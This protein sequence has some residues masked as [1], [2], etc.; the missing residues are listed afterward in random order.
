M[1]DFLKNVQAAAEATGKDHSVTKA[2]ADF[3]R[4]VYP[5]GPVRLRF[6]SYVELGKHEKTW[7]GQTK[8]KELVR[9]GFEVSG[10][11]HKPVIG[12]DGVARPLVLYVEETLSQDPKANWV[13]L[14]SLLN[15]DR[16]ATHAVQLLGRAYK[17]MLTHRKYKRRDDPA[18]QDKWTGLDYKIRGDGGY[19]IQAPFYEDQETGD[20]KPLQ[21][22]PPI[23]KMAA[24]LW[25]NPSQEQWDSIFIEGEYP[26]RKN[27]AGVVTAPAKS[28][29]AIQ[30]RVLAAVNFKGSPLHTML[31]KA[32]ANLDLGQAEQADYDDGPQGE[33]PAPKAGTKPAASAQ[34]DADFDADF[35][36]PF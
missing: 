22:D 23:T 21:V 27:E 29:N 19:T 15:H 18:E 7:K 34:G 35:D 25:D 4:I 14:F 5:E 36:I 8:V 32:G 26:E 24:L 6:I 20:M 12:A 2:G 28:K 13:K 31:V 3:E 1:T 33:G 9:L 11:K 10:P 30:Q 16:S 17:A